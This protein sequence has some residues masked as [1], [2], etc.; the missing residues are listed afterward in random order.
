MCVCMCKV[1]VCV[2]Y[3]L[4]AIHQLICGTLQSKFK[5]LARTELC[6]MCYVVVM[7]VER[8]RQRSEEEKE[9]NPT[10]MGQFENGTEFGDDLKAFSV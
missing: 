5:S 7:C 1:Y 2:S 9:P 4:G 3:H 6:L 8:E 10:E